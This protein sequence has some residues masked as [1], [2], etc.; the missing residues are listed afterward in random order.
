[1][2]WSQTRQATTC[3][4]PAQRLLLPRGAAGRPRNPEDVA[5]L[6][7][8]AR[9]EE[10]G[11]RPG[12]TAPGDC[13]RFADRFTS[14]VDLEAGRDGSLYVTQLSDTGWTSIFGG[15]GE[16]VPSVE[17]PLEGSVIRLKNGERTVLGNGKLALPGGVGVSRHGGVFVARVSVPFFGIP[18]SL[19]KLR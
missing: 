11:L 17:A 10:R 13:R 6:A 16:R 9:R 12:A 4:G 8:Q 3:S 7:D 15:M 1:M 2:C 19:V 14:I 18:G 5:D